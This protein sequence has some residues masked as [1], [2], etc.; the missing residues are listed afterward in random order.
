MVLSGGWVVDRC[1][2]I[3]LEWGGGSG[4]VVCDVH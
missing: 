1:S 3:Y 2:E 4:E